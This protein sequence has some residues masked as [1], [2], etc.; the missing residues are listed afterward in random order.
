MQVSQRRNSAMEF[1]IYSLVQFLEYIEVISC[2]MFF[3]VLCVLHVLDVFGLFSP[4]S[5]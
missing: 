3:N 4:E 2:S 5:C 1:A